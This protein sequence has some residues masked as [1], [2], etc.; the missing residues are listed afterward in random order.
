MID[1]KSLENRI[2]GWFPQEPKIKNQTFAVS[3]NLPKTQTVPPRRYENSIDDASMLWIVALSLMLLNLG[4]YNNLP[5]ANFIGFVVFGAVMGIFLVVVPAYRE[6]QT[7][8]KTGL[9]SVK[10]SEI[11]RH[12]LSVAGLCLIVGFLIGQFP[13]TLKGS[14]AVF[15]VSSALSIIVARALL[16]GAWERKNKAD[17]WQ[18]KGYSLYSVPKKSTEP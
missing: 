9:S 16:F 8:F 10:L 1:R 4:G 17:L 7:L 12:A 18:G 6:L 2:R 3:A 13:H 15:F 11:T 14:I 5:F